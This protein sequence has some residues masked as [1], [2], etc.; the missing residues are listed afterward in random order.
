VDYNFR[1]SDMKLNITYWSKRDLVCPTC[2]SE[3]IVLIFFVPEKISDV[4]NATEQGKIQL[5]SSDK[6]NNVEWLCKNCYD[7]G[8]LSEDDGELEK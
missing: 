4:I 7:V 5:V 1:D 3:N 8:K 2:K 6:A